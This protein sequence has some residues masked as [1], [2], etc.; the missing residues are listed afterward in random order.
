MG[1]KIGLALGSGAAKGYA[2]IGVIKV[3]EKYGI[4]IHIITGSSIG[5]LIGALY[6]AGISLKTIE[7]LAYNIKRRHFLDITLPK[8][9][10]I[11]GNK[12]YE[13]LKLLTKNKD[14][15]ELNIPLGV[16]VTE[17]KSKKLYIL[18]EGNVAFAVRASI[19]IPGIFNP[20]F[21]QDGK[22]FVDG[23]VLERVP[24][25]AAREMGADIVIGVEL[26]FSERQRFHTIYDILFETFDVMGREI[27]NLKGYDCDVLITPH[28]ERINPMAFGEPQYCIEE[29]VKAA[30]RAIPHI[31]SLLEEK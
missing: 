5:S 10:L 3:L 17:L 4:P 26:G 25:K 29:G 8:S 14:F 6:S 13:M 22:I 2:H 16:A 30:E 15:S 9:G 24:G 23:G 20:V 1:K 12:I 11:A 7:G 18:N 27:Q 28:L 19:S 21:T 31:L